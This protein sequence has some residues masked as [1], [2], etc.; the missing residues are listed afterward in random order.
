ME[1]YNVVMRCSSYVRH[2]R[3]YKVAATHL[4]MDITVMWQPSFTS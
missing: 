1:A 2:V 3:A 4:Q